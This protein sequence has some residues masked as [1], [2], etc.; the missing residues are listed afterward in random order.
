MRNTAGSAFKLGKVAVWLR[1]CQRAVAI[2]ALTAL[3]GCSGSPAV[4]REAPSIV[5]EYSIEIMTIEEPEF[6]HN[7]YDVRLTFDLVSEAPFPYSHLVQEIV[8]STSMTLGNGRPVSSEISLVEAF[9]LRSRGVGDDGRWYYS[10]E[11]NQRDRHFESGFQE[12]HPNLREVRVK[13]KV[14]LYPAVVEGADFTSLGFA[15]LPANRDGSVE[16]RVPPE[17]NRRYQQSHMTRGR[18]LFDDRD[19]GSQSYNINYRW[20][21]NQGG[22]VSFDGAIR[23]NGEIPVISTSGSEFS[24]LPPTPGDAESAGR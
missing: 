15:H 22:N 10:L 8:Q 5:P 18:V 24:S 2:A 11:P 21:R 1:S 4:I 3:L 7:G 23:A 17:F 16:T 20:E 14:R 6:S 9:R 12:A 19:L 13:R